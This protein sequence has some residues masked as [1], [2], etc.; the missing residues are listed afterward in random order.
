M[1]NSRPIHILSLFFI[2]LLSLGMMNHV[3]VI[4]M[5]LGAAARDAWLVPMIFLPI[6]ALWLALL[7]FILKRISPFSFNDWLD[8]HFG[9][10]ISW[11]IRIVLSLVTLFMGITTLFDTV[12]WTHSTYLQTTP[13]VVLAAICL[14]VSGTVA[15]LGIGPLAITSGVLLPMVSVLGYFVSFTNHK[16]K[17]YKYLFPILEHGWTPVWQGMVH[18]AGGL[19]ELWIILIIRHRV[20]GQIRYWQLLLLGFLLIGLIIGPTI[21]AITEFGPF[22]AALQRDPAYEQWRLVK[23]GRFI[24]HVD[25]LSIFQWLSGAYVR[26]ALATYLS[27]E[28]W[29]LQKMKHRL[30][31][32]LA[33]GSFLLIILAVGATRAAVEI[34]L[35]QMQFPFVLSVSLSFTLLLGLM[36]LIFRHRK[37]RSL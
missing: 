6:L 7:H 18:V 20:K 16:Y 4:P 1:N 2:L 9:R 28:L 5:L 22:E 24:E 26:I 37:D 12:N 15:V 35:Q 11:I 34:F 29:N 21:G 27:L 17:D 13:T 25:F 10:A 23:I 30:L 14:I 32:T 33:I 36:M 19:L 31:A 8:K 3:M